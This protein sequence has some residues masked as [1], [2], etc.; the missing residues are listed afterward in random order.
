MRNEF[1]FCAPQLKRIP[2]D[3]AE[4]MSLIDYR[5]GRRR[6]KWVPGLIFAVPLTDRSWGVGQTSELMMP[7]W[8]YC[9]LF[10]ERLPSL[11]AAVPRPTKKDLVALLAVARQGLA[12]GYWP[13][14]GTGP[15]VFGKAEFPNERLAAS[16]YVGAQ[17]YDYGLGEELLSAFHGLTP[18]NTYKEEDYLDTMLAPGVARPAAAKVLSA[19]E[20]AAYRAAKG[21]DT[22][23]GA[24]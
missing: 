6:V 14:I 11:D 16:G 24:V 17:M 8:G 7:H 21:W 23:D 4:E 22:S 13:V 1:F 2:L 19:A 15:A 20:R 18:W 10:S 3:G 12:S 9:A 5:P